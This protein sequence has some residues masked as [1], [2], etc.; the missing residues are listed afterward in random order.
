[1]SSPRVVVLGLSWL[2]LSAAGLACGR[3]AEP[4][5]VADPA[6][7]RSPP[8][9]D[10]V[11]FTGGY[12]SHVWLGLPFAAPP[13]GER[14]WRAP[15]AAPRWDGERAALE[16]G[17]PCP[18]YASVYAGL[19]RGSEGVIG[20][21]DCLVLD[22]WAPAMEPAA[23]AAAR[24]PVMVWFH[25]GG[26]SIGGT[27][28]YDGGNLARTGQVVVVAAQYRLG[29]LGWLRHEA[30]RATATTPEDRSGNFG[31]LD[32]IRALEWVRDNAAAFGGDPGN[33]T[34]FGESAG[35]TNVLALLLAPS[36]AGLFHRAILESPGMDTVVA[37]YAERFHDDTP[38]GHPHS[39]NEAIVQMMVSEGLAPDG[40]EARAKLSA[41]P[42]AELAAW[43]RSRTPAQLLA[44]YTEHSEGMLWF[45]SVFRDGHV[46]PD[47]E[48]LALLAAGRYHHV[49]TLL[50]T[51]RDENKLFMAFDPELA[52]WRFG[53]FPQPRDPGRYAAQADASARAW[54]ARAVDEPARRMRAVQG[55][56]VYGYRFDWDEEPSLPWLYDGPAMLGA[57][58]GFEIPFVFGHWDL[59]PESSRLFTRWN[60]E[61]REA[62][63][64]AM[65]S[66]WA[67]FAATGAPGRGRN[68]EL[69]E[70]QPWDASSPEAPKYAVLDT[71]AGGG[72]RMASETWTLERVVAELLADPR[73]QDDRTRCAVLRAM[74][75]WNDLPRDQYASAGGGVCADYALDA[76]P[77]PDVAAADTR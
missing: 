34:I 32:T 43:L 25:G 4:L 71:P 14:R 33:V 12:G 15:A 37:G 51:N 67:Q 65:L 77:W 58:H 20:D 45:P 61:G 55:P 73:V 3:P 19:P 46:I 53:L 31:T 18:Q 2:A 44:G 28:F 24:L 42:A 63:S 22:V 60:R 21:E 30:L 69:P 49:P 47:A 74:T 26:H 10:V 48:P 64:A 54:K 50:G 35:G 27:A 68:G 29:P 6:T 7:R 41:M 62:L 36:G 70:W 66:Y 72:V 57:S 11:G 9:G 16:H 59:G 56:T 13:V 40:A 75:L 1:M 5:P 17:A 23:A 39:A 76:Y 52:R 8:A 38:P